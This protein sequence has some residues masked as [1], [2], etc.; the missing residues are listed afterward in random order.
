MANIATLKQKALKVVSEY[1]K[2][3]L[4]CTSYL[5]QNE[6]G[7]LLTVVDIEDSAKTHDVYIS[8]VVRIIGEIINID[9]DQ[10]NK[11]AVDALIQA[12][13]NRKNIVLAYAGEVI[14]EATA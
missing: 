7:S 12:G 11:P 9:R 4:N 13:I 8:L 6:D 3:G 14:P 5:T 2:D 10:N 1:A